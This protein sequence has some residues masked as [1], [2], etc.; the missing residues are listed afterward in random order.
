MRASPPIQA[1][2]ALPTVALAMLAAGCGGGSHPPGVASLGAPATT[3]TAAAP[4][5]SPA[6]GGSGGGAT[7]QLKTADAAKF[8]ACMRKHGVPTFPDPGQNGAISIGPGSGLDPG[9][10]T[11]QAAQRQCS[12]LLPNGGRPSP[13]QLAKMRAGALAFS[14]CM[15]RHGVTDFPDPTFSNG[16]VQLKVTARAGSGLD[17]RSATFQAAQRACNSKLPGRVGGATGGAK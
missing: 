8:S 7:L 16:G 17:P 9:S 4:G 5:D 6:P 3:T 14:A 1:A 11:F 15:R 10:A 12:S 2:L 13:Q